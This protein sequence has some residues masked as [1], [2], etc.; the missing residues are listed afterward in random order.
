MTVSKLCLVNI[1]PRLTNSQAILKLAHD[2]H[3]ERLK[4][5]SAYACCLDAFTQ[6]VVVHTVSYSF[7]LACSHHSRDAGSPL[8]IF[9]P[10]NVN[11]MLEWCDI[12]QPG[13]GVAPPL[14]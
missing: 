14:S 8:I 9:K 7:L 3:S 12:R 1:I 5:P 2:W 4:K 10:P 13:E 11:H 6:A